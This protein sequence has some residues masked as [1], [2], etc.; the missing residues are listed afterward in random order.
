M[1]TMSSGSPAAYL[2]PGGAAGNISPGQLE[3]SNVFYLGEAIDSMELQ[4][5]I[6][7]NL[8]IV[9]MASDLITQFINRLG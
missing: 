3:Q 5:A 4:R 1:E 9:R 2:A 7:G 6:N 8:S